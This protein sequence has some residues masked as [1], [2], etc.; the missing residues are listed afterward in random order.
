MSRSPALLQVT[1]RPTEEASKV[2]WYHPNSSPTPTLIN[3]SQTPRIINNKKH[4]HNLYLILSVTD[5]RSKVAMSKSLSAKRNE[6]SP[7]AECPILKPQSF[8]F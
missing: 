2:N 3:P 4:K 1:K 5:A 6:Q 7:S 8:C